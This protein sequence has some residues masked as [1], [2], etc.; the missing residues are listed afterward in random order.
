MDRASMPSD[1][2]QAEAATWLVRL[3]RE[4]RSGADERAF[5]DWLAADASHAVAFE[6]VSTTWDMTGALPRDLRGSSRHPHVASRRKVM[7]GAAAVLA[8]G[9]SFAFWKSAQADTY[10]TDVGEQKHVSLDDGTRILLDTNTRLK[11]RFTETQRTTDLQYGRVN[12]QVS[13]DPARPFVVNAGKSRIV[14]APASFD[15]RLDGEQLSVVL[16]R[17]G[18]QVLRPA[19]QPEQLRDGDRLIV[20]TKGSG[21]RDRPA[22]TPLLA[23]QTAQ[24]IFEDGRLSDAA[25]EMNRYSSVKLEIADP[26]VRN[27]RVSGIYAVGDNVAFANSVARLLPVNIL[28]GEGRIEI[29]AKSTR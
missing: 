4:A 2:V 23:W 17:G 22:M 18:A 19:A 16:I 27:L 25:S 8:G 1:D 12:F 24:A 13:G 29:V 26:A 14:P 3:Q 15:V 7:A 6:A 28:Q 20:D 5:Q 11:V 9:A 10:Q 21:R